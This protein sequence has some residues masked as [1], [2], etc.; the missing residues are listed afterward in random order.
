MLPFNFD[1]LD[2]GSIFLSNVAGFHSCLDQSEFDEFIESS[3]TSNRTLNDL[4]Q[5]KLFVSDNDN[6]DATQ[7]ALSSALAKKLLGELEFR[8]IFMIVPTLRCDHAC[9]Y[10]QVSRANAKASG[11]DL[12]PN[13]IS[14]IVST[15]KRLSPPP[16]KIEIQ[17]GEPLLRMDLIKAIYD[18]AES[19]LQP[20]NFELVI[21]TS[22][23]LMDESILSWARNRAVYFSTSLDGQQEVHNANRIL[24]S[25]DSYERLKHS[26]KRILEELGANRIATVTT[27]TR[28]LL[29]A[30]E[31]IIEAHLELGINEMFVR[32][33]SPYGFA[34]T[35]PSTEYSIAE[36]MT[37]YEKLFN[38]IIKHNQEGIPLVESSAAIHLKRVLIPGYS[39][40]A[41]LKSPSGL[42]LNCVLFNYDSKVYGSDETRML[43]RVIG[44]IDFSCGE[45]N[46]LSLV[47]NDLYQ[48]LISSSFNLVH[49]G[50]ETCAYQPYCGSDPCQHISLM[51]EPVGDK[52]LSVFCH[53]HKNMFRFLLDRYYSHPPTRNILKDWCHG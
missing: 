26:V 10:C 4:L 8:P 5:S 44:D 13:A 45:V 48:K 40:Y 6:L 23:S 14:I 24:P 16:Y 31:S 2:S 30:P 52:S 11:Y 39:Q 36:Y 9:N 51:G 35:K 21:T 49:P 53:Y 42:L 43:Q 19:Q 38:T 1:R 50:C 3:A 7:A 32:P 47:K 22:L 33:I 20:G 15:I 41:D 17:G 27:V 37:F 12:D 25:Q 18:Q 34:N 29:E 28:S 46:S